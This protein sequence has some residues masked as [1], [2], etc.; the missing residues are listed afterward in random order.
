LEFGDVTRDGG[1][2]QAA[3]MPE[4]TPPS[5]AGVKKRNPL[6]RNSGMFARCPLQLSLE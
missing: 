3:G 2:A 5:F 4:T 6:R 1:A